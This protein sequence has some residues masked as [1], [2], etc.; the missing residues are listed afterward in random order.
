MGAWV[1]DRATIE[2]ARADAAYVCRITWAS[3]AS[4]QTEWVYTC[5]RIGKRLVA[6]GNGVKTDRVY[7]EGGALVSSATRYTDGAAEFSVGEDGLLSWE[8]RKEEAGAG[9][10]FERLPAEALPTVGEFL[11]EFYRTVGGYH[12]GVAGAGLALANAACETVRFAAAHK[13]W[14]ADPEQL[15]EAPLAAWKKLSREEQT[16][17]AAN[18]LS[19][20][21]LVDDCIADWQINRPRFEDAGSADDMA[22]LLSDPIAVAAWKTLRAQMT[23][24]SGT[25]G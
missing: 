3:S 22:A 24:L 12:Q 20:I 13:L 5:G 10:A 4:E 18:Y 15:R 6:E 2:I 17:F 19:V 9:M 14:C 16:D 7:A 1:C 21:S 8:D 23:A 25:F 11:D